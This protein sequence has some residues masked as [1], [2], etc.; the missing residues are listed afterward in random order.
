MP[1]VTAS[2]LRDPDFLPFKLDFAGRRV[3]FV[4]MSSEQRAAASFLDERLWDPGTHGIWLSLDTLL[5]NGPSI[6]APG[7]DFIFHI[8]HC[9]STLLSRLL[10]SWPEVQVLREPLPLRTLAEAG[11]P[12]TAPLPRQFQVIL[13]WLLERWGTPCAPHRRTLV[14]ATSSC[15]GL[16]NSILGASQETRAVLLDVPLETY[17]AT[18]MKSEA[19]IRDAAVSAPERRQTLARLT[20]APSLASIPERPWE[21]CAMGWLAEQL[22]FAEL[23]AHPRSGG[24]VL[25]IDFDRL[26]GNPRS[27]L[28]QISAH[29]R[30]GKSNL[31]CAL[32]SP[33]WNRYSKAQ[34]YAYSV[35]DRDH[36][37]GLSR[38]RF[39]PQILAGRTWVQRFLE[40]HPELS[41]ADMR[42]E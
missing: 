19:S 23:A 35:D 41:G 22:R 33:A 21:M 32:A 39:G 16:I 31:E 1:F 17:L 27:V 6:P 37:M 7:P 29:L 14:K 8:G 20:A 30:L 24:Q 26:L 40:A 25:R 28:T 34:S 2:P 36:D 3:L 11:A 5:E 18:L 9:G 38:L 12:Q 15:N 13:S 10:Q 4:R 42:L